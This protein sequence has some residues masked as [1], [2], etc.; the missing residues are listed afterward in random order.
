MRFLLRLQWLKLKNGLT[1]SSTGETLKTGVFLFLAALF[2][3]GLYLGFVRLLTALRDVELIGSLLVMRVLSM[4]FLTTFLM[5]VFSSTLS[6][7]STLFFARDLGMLIHTPLPYRTLFLFKS[8][9]TAVFSSWMVVVALAPFLAAYGRVMGQGPVFY[10]VLLVLAVPFVWTA[11]ALGIGLSLGL[12]SVFPARR[13]R[14]VMLTLAIVIT[15]GLYLWVRWLAPAKFVR[16]DTLE[17]VIQYIAQL[18]APTA[19]YLP[20]WWM[21]MA[22][23]GFTAQRGGD[24]GSYGMILLCV[25][26]LLGALL[27]AVGERVYY[28]GWAAAQESGRRRQSTPL[29]NEWRGVPRFLGTPLRAIVGK[30]VTLFRRDSNQWSQLLMLFSIVAVY[31]I[32]IRKLPLDTPF[33][34]GLISFLN[35]GMVGFVLASVALR[36]VFPEISLEGR[37]W[38]ALRS[39]PLSLWSIL[40][41]KFLS[42]V[43]PLGA[44][45][46]V[47]V[48]VSNRFLHVDPFVVWLS[49]AT[50]GVMA[51]TLTAMGVGFGA[52]F[53]RMNMENVA[54]IQTS[55]GGV[56][57]MVSALFYVGLTLALEA[58]VMRMYYFQKL[59]GPSAWSGG[60]VLW[61]VLSLLAVNAVAFGVPLVL[62]KRSLESADI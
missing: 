27:V 62:G 23:T 58:V 29:G 38:W 49:N 42:G 20:S 5:I 3:G 1:R 8:L 45:G 6:S 24:T 54:Q 47:L 14:E 11:S 22:V 12:M 18:E 41:G 57:Y 30:D 56:L 4:A 13:V 34:R 28:S 60:V 35:I 21:T 10:G 44:A 33:L 9:E 53:P 2:M 15:T 32:S 43:V 55:M 7:F 39:A 31:L 16:A 51:L 19:V 50:V 48:W 61:V 37:A 26:L 46:V 25:A 36:F 40:W 52:L 59:A 17:L